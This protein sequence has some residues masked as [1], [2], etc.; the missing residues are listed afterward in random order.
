M[1]SWIKSELIDIDSELTRNS[2][3]VNSQ[4]N[5]VQS[6]QTIKKKKIPF[7]KKKSFGFFPSISNLNTFL[8]K[9]NLFT[10]DSC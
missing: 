10:K 2:C 1:S 8:I 9:K 4:S 3:H 5:C 6:N 7:Q